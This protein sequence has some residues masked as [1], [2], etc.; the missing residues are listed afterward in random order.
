MKADQRINI[1]SEITIAWIKMEKKEMNKNKKKLV[2][3]Y[4]LWETLKG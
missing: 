1:I 2:L 4:L 3:I